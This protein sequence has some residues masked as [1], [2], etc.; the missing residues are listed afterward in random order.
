MTILHKII[1][2]SLLILAPLQHVS[3]GNNS[4]ADYTTPTALVQADASWRTHYLTEAKNEL[5]SAYES[6]YGSAFPERTYN[7]IKS[8]G[9]E[10]SLLMA[11]GP[12]PRILHN[13]DR[14]KRELRSSTADKYA[15]M[16]FAISVARRIDGVGQVR[17]S[18]DRFSNPAEDDYDEPKIS[19][20]TLEM[21][22][23]LE[24]YMNKKGWDTEKAYEK[25]Q[26]LRKYLKR[27][28]STAFDKLHLKE[29]GK[30]GKFLYHY[31]YTMGNIKEHAPNASPAEYINYIASLDHKKVDEFIGKGN[32]AFSWPK[33]FSHNAP[34]PLLMPL[35][36]SRPIDEMEYIWNRFADTSE[37]V[38]HRVRKYGNYRKSFKRGSYQAAVKFHEKSLQYSNIVGGLCGTQSEVHRG[39]FISLGVP[40]IAC[41]QPGHAAALRYYH[42]EDNNK[43]Y[44]AMGLSTAQLYNTGPDWHF[45][46]ENSFRIHESGRKTKGEYPVGLPLAINETGIQG[47]LDNRTL[48]RL[49]DAEKNKN[50]KRTL[51][52]EAVDITLY[53]PEAIY[54]LHDAMGGDLKS[55]MTLIN[56]LMSEMEVNDDGIYGPEG[57]TPDSNLANVTEFEHTL[58]TSTG[59]YRDT[60]I[61][62]LLQKSFENNS[63]FPY[64]YNDWIVKL[65]DDNFY[66]LARFFSYEKFN[67]DLPKKG[68]MLLDKVRREIIERNIRAIVD[69]EERRLR[70]IKEA[71]ERRLKAKK[72]EEARQVKIDQLQ[73]QI[74]SG[75]NGKR[76]L[77]RI[78]RLKQQ[79]EE[80]YKN[81]N[82]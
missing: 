54:D 77:K 61:A 55:A 75:R 82:S 51:L 29:D 70:E 47:Y 52:K 48:V 23:V 30:L 6:K 57:R 12:D 65:N 49:A 15:N 39:T 18:T 13:I 74:D 43:Y 73:Q 67:S 38:L 68:K 53:N 56:R 41:S 50:K 45:F 3:A 34:W 36:E 66:Q 81:L 5:I 71:E 40:V 35:A 20:Y 69:A 17:Y 59:N 78:N 58:D 33:I 19:S 44:G 1:L 27:K 2:P 42:D 11:V 63:T 14:I 37:D 10:N 79:S 9:L 7:W 32:E 21:I 64:G 8:K 25:R 46:E 72:E 28:N 62:A 24:P 4:P 22:D 60:V 16:V 76:L 80:Y 26:T 31:N